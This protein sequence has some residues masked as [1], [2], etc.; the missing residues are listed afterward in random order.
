MAQYRV[1]MRSTPGFYTQYDGH[2]DV[3]AEDA[4]DAKE[5]AFLK[6]RNGAFSDRGRSMWK[7]EKIEALPSGGSL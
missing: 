2:V 6:L 3:E 5:A 4:E 1:W 7:Y